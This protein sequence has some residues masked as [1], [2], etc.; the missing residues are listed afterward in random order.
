MTDEDAETL[1]KLQYGAG[2]WNSCRNMSTI[3]VGASG[4]FGEGYEVWTVRKV[5]N[6]GM[7]EG[8]RG[9]CAEADSDTKEIRI[10]KFDETPLPEGLSCDH[11][12]LLAHEMGHAFGLGNVG[13]RDNPNPLCGPSGDTPGS[14]MWV[15]TPRFPRGMTTETCHTALAN[16][17]RE[18]L[19]S[20]EEDPTQEGC[21]GPQCAVAGSGQCP[22]P[23][24]PP[25]TPCAINPF[26]VGCACW[27]NEYHWGCDPNCALDPYA[28]GCDANVCLGGELGPVIG[29]QGINPGDPRDSGG[30]FTASA[31]SSTNYYTL[32]LKG[33]A[34]VTLSV[35]N[36]SR[37]FDCNVDPGRSDRA[38]P[39]PAGASDPEPQLCSNRIGT[40]NDTW[41]GT[42][43]R[44][45][46]RISVWPIDQTA[47]GD[48]TLTVTARLPDPP[49]TTVL[50]VT[51][52]NSSASRIHSYEL[53]FKSQ[54][55]VSITNL[56]TNFD[57]TVDSLHS[58]SNQAGTADDSW[59]GILD[60]GSHEVSVYPQP[61]GTGNY[62]L[63]VTATPIVEPPANPD[64]NSDDDDDDEDEDDDDDEDEDDDDDPDP[65][66]APALSGSVTVT[67]HTLTWTAPTS[68]SDITG[69]RLQSRA[70]ATANWSSPT[71]G[72][73]TASSLSA[74]TLTWNIAT[75]AS[76]VRFYRVA[77]S[78]EDGEGPWS[79]EIKLTSHGPPA[80]VSITGSVSNRTQTV[81][82]TAPQSD[83]AI[84]KYQLQTRSASGSWRWPGSGSPTASN[85]PA[86]T[87][88]WSVN[89]PA[90]MTRHY[91]VRAVSA[92]GDGAWSS[93]VEL[94][95][96]S[97]PPLSAP[98]IPN[99]DNLASA[100]TVNTTF[101]VATGGTPPYSYSLSGRPPGITFNASTRVASGTLPIVSR[102]TTYNLTY[103]VTD[104]ARATDSESF[105][106]TV[107]PPPRPG[108][109]TLSGSVTRQTQSLSWTVPT[110]SVPITGYQLQVRNSSTS[111]WRCTSAGS[112]TASCSL[113]A[114]TT[115]WSVTT[116]AGMTRH[117]RVRASNA[118]GSG[119]WSNEVVLTSGGG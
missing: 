43:G 30:T 48:Y 93:H 47:S 36:M 28:S 119:G 39:G 71:G 105:T 4:A 23:D 70:S 89:T 44:G 60:K 25:P 91:R 110:S 1:A 24:P 41:T 13:D 83:S 117:Y 67:T 32:R 49:T 104:S 46:H 19:P 55:E 65:P 118:G 17:G 7:A 96:A 109:P 10:N 37:D 5:S 12:D 51:V 42:L 8:N 33:T 64:D 61:S 21:G 58:C 103:T 18:I 108:A 111:R 57:C 97:P 52:T 15:G 86:T 77:A 112:A 14:L 78:N 29:C 20:C 69:Y 6:S 54:V 63:T 102:R 87:R 2:V 66:G 99:F 35:T 90:G 92:L 114:S 72:S 107:V 113:S 76:A 115:S 31:A 94:T 9:N 95:S 26:S 16:L 38:R 81:S 79:N 82:W 85:M 40:V 53:E 68:S 84:T 50:D 80:Q 100:R 27:L 62:T 73:A 88:S 22:S 74:T 34:I 106:A 75:S 101:P 3:K 56:S 45:T 98:S 59:S 11:A 116:P